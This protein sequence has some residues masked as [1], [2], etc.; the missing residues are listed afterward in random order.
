MKLSFSTATEAAAP[1]LA[2]L[3]TAVA[4]DLTLRYGHGFWSSA[5]S[6][7]G[8]LFGMRHSR[9]LIAKKGKK[10]VATLRLAT[11]KPWAIDVSYFT[12]V[13]KALYL[14]SMAVIPKMQ[15]HGI[16]RLLLDE[17]AKQAQAWPVGA[18]RLDAFDANAGAG[19]FYAKCGFREVGRVIYRKNPLIYYEL[20]L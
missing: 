2:A 17:A 3:H 19:E 15:R 5:A 18:I 14:T 12:P 11:K 10:V 4:A 13:K 9:V 6:E 16:G 1:A 8:V 7:K 20:V